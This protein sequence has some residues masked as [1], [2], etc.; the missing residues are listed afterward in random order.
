MTPYLSLY[1]ARFRTLLQYRL[2][3]FAGFGTQLFWG[4]IRMMIFQAF[5]DS[6]AIA[7]PMSRAQAVTYIWLGQ[8]M[9]GLLPWNLDADIRALMR[10]GTVAY[11]LLRPMDLYA[12]WYARAVA[13]RTAPTLLRCIPLFLVAGLFFGLRPPAS[14]VAFVEWLLTTAGAVALGC[15]FGT[16]MNVTLVTTVAGEGIWRFA[17]PLTYTLSGMLIPIS[18]LPPA[19]IPIVNALPFRGL[20][21][22]PFRAYLGLLTPR[23]LAFGLLHQACWTIALVATGRMLLRRTIGHMVIQGG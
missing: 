3:A 1:G 5:Y 23:D 11:E 18:L 17:A 19:F 2:A 10:T 9:L 15:A 22:T 12:T 8:A 21:D 7:Q 4:I 16:L 20:V 6:S 13:Q 14:P